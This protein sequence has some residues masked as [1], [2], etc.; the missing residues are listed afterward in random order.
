MLRHSE[1][2]LTG[3]DGDLSDGRPYDDTL[4]VARKLEP[5]V[6]K[7]SRGLTFAMVR[8]I[9]YVEREMDVSSGSAGVVADAS[10]TGGSV[11]PSSGVDPQLQK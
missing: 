5:I 3:L 6:A 11:A 4:M 7:I 8:D 1:L 2:D 9:R 10:S